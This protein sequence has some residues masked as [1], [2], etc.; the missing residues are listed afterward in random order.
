YEMCGRRRKK[1]G[2]TRRKDEIKQKQ[3]RGVSKGRT[4]SVRAREVSNR[5]WK[6]HVLM[7]VQQI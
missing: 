7:E 5:K 4:E 3:R 2:L 6:R 1:I